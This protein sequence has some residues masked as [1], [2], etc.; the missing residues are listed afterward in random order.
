MTKTE[1]EFETLQMVEHDD[2]PIG[3]IDPDASPGELPGLGPDTGSRL[4]FHNY[5]FSEV[6]DYSNLEYTELRTTLGANYRVTQ[7]ARLFGAVSLFDLDD[8]QPYIQDATG[9]VTLVSG[10]VT[11]TF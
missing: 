7:A 8:E 9:A 2:V 1:A 10:G 5:D 11:W 4:R 3:E 6:H